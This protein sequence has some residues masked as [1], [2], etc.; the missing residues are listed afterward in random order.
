MGQAGRKRDII[1]A[2]CPLWV[3][4]RMASAS[5]SMAVRQQ[6]CVTASLMLR[7]GLNWK[8]LKRPQ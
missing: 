8:R 2:V 4:V 7:P 6:V 1:L 5:R 3:G